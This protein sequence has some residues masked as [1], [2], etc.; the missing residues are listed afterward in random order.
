MEMRFQM[1]RLIC[2]ASLLATF[3]LLV[4]GSLLST[5]RSAS[6]GQGKG[7]EVVA[8]P[9]PTPK[10]T[11]TKKSMAKTTRTNG[12]PSG[13]IAA[14]E[15]AFWA[16]IKDSTDPAD[17]KAY[18][19][20]YPNGK[21]VTLARNRLKNLASKANPS[22][23]PAAQT[24]TNPTNTNGVNAKPENPNNSTKPNNASGSTNA[25]PG[26][27]TVVR[28]QIGMEL[29][30][31]PPGSFMMGSNN[32]PAEK[33]VHQVTISNGFYIGRYEVT[34]AQWQVVMGTTVAQQRDKGNPQ[35][36][37][38][39]EGDNYP[40][41]YVRWNEAQEFIEKLNQ[42]N[43]GY[44]YRLPT[45]AE[46]EYACRAGTTGDY[47]GTL[48]AMAWYGN[49]SGQHYLDAAEIWRTD[50]SNDKSNWE[51]RLYD[52]GNQTHPVGTK[53]PN[54]FGLFD[55]SGNVWEWCQD[56]SHD[57]YNGAPTDGSAWLGGGEQRYRVLRGG[58]CNDSVI[59]TRSA[60][61]WWV[62]PGTRYY[63][64]GFRVVAVARTQ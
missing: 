36:P 23:T 3:A 60:S 24:E 42:T 19:E 5:N 38:R 26:P 35:W 53:Q 39:G 13:R 1:R 49:N 21:F 41:Y 59:D 9:T 8:K 18:L 34:Q 7:G 44:A 14:D 55:M 28:N 47:A 17:F 58:G 20:Q 50:K 12:S 64:V 37:L 45:E 25:A 15:I 48:D 10:K 6:A 4:S 31:I 57:S 27:G 54:A 22:T 63:V 62:T 56:W 30:W 29:V 2:I 33:P 11:T 43:D 51:K 52:N 40:M 16:S 46:W 61:R 32:Y